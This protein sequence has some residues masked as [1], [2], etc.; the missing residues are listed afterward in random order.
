MPPPKPPLYLTKGELDALRAA[1]AHYEKVLEDEWK[2]PERL[3]AA[4]WKIEQSRHKTGPWRKPKDKM[5]EPG[6]P[7]KRESERAG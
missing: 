1:V 4:M 3:R 5:E 2:S 6:S 7:G